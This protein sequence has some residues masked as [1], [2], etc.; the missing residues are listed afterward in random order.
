LIRFPG[1]IT[2]CLGCIYFYAKRYDEALN[3]FDKAI[4]LNPDFFVT[5]YHFAWLYAQL[6]EYPNAIT[7]LSK[8]RRLAGDNRAKIA[9]AQEVGLRRAFA[10][11]GARGFWLQIQKD[12]EKNVSTERENSAVRKSMPG[13][14]TRRRH[15]RN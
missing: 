1:S 2:R 4:K 6:G 8:G 10:A 5:H 12:G 7:E 13:S 9:A 11:E 14:E 3:Q 15:C